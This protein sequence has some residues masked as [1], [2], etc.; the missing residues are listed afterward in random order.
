MIRSFLK[1]TAGIACAIALATATPARAGQITIDS[2]PGCSSFMF[3]FCISPSLSNGNFTIHNNTTEWSVT[4]F[5]VTTAPLAVVPPP[6]PFTPSNPSDNASASTTRPN[7]SAALDH[8][9]VNP[10]VSTLPPLFCP[11]FP[12]PGFT[13]EPTTFTTPGA[14]KTLFSYTAADNDILPGESDGGFSWQRTSTFGLPG[15]DLGGLSLGADPSY[16][17]F[18]AGIGDDAMGVCTGTLGSTGNFIGPSLTSTCDAPSLTVAD[19]SVPEPG[20]L[21]LLGS[22]L[23]GF[24]LSRR[25]KRSVA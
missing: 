24:A 5:V 15:F 23:V 4:R 22:G 11:P 13:C 10:I 1:L 21:A 6:P 14:Y 19:G 9:G 8:V 12:I 3:G 2:T 18:L 17:I 20:S 16:T 7:W 25:R